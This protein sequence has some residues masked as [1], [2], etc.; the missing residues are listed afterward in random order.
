[1]PHSPPDSQL[2]IG[3]QEE[4]SHFQ[5]M[6]ICHRSL[7]DL[8]HELKVRKSVHEFDDISSLAANLLL[9]RCPR[10]MRPEYPIE[11]VQLLDNLGRIL[12]R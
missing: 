6:L 3:I 7:L 2:A 12:A 5:D 10:I 8:L 9:A 1:M 11:V 4:V